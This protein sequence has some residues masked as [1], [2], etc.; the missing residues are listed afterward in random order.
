MKPWIRYTDIGKTQ[1]ALGNYNIQRT[2]RGHE[3]DEFVLSKWTR[4]MGWVNVHIARHRY[5]WF[6]KRHG[7][8]RYWK[9]Q[10]ETPHGS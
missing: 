5:L 6:A 1:W 10:Y 7:Q 4:G 9:D 3:R 8:Y 2:N